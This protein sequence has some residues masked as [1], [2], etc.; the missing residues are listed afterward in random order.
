MFFRFINVNDFDQCGNGASVKDGPVLRHAEATSTAIT[1]LTIVVIFTF[2][3]QV[4]T[5]LLSNS[6][7]CV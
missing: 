4:F 3:L 7:A 2:D 5:I 6:R 1:L